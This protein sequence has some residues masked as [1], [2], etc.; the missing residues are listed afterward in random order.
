ML[1]FLKENVSIENE[2]IKIVVFLILSIFSMG[3]DVLI[4]YLNGN[5]IDLIVIMLVIS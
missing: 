3:I 4:T 2:K 5:F 1:K